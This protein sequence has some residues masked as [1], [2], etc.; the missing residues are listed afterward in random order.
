VR[1][2]SGR[3]YADKKVAGIVVARDLS[4]E[5]LPVFQRQYGG[6]CAGNTW[7]CSSSTLSATLILSGP[8]RISRYAQTIIATIYHRTRHSFPGPLK[9]TRV[10]PVY[11]RWRNATRCFYRLFGQQERTTRCFLI[12]SFFIFYFVFHFLLFI[13]FFI[14]L[15]WSFMHICFSVA[16]FTQFINICCSSVR[17][18]FPR[19]NPLPPILCLELSVSAHIIS[20]YPLPRSFPFAFQS[21][22]TKAP[23]S[24]QSIVHQSKR[25]AQNFGYVGCCLWPRR[26]RF[27]FFLRGVWRD[28]T[29]FSWLGWVPITMGPLLA[30]SKIGAIDEVGDAQR[31]SRGLSGC[32]SQHP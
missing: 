14:F 18:F 2:R 27:R 26:G 20:S 23:K 25:S 29:L 15:S 16:S 6:A 13:L 9:V 17:S 3:L 22:I 31:A 8:R 10:L 24:V 30:E 1:R 5:S 19:G 12:P 7:L 4:Q 11:C 28:I 32:P 21:I